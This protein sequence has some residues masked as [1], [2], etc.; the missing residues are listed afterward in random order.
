M[1]VAGNDLFP[2]DSRACCE[3]S[4][5]FGE[6]CARRTSSTHI[7]M[8]SYVR[9][10]TFIFLETAFHNFCIQLQE[11]RVDI[12]VQNTEPVA[13]MGFKSCYQGHEK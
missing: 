6:N 10:G 5:Q 7:R 12:N 8:N 11:R 13:R 3:S 1:Y 2:K 4:A 9:V